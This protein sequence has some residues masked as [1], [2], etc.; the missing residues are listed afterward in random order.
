[1]ALEGRWLWDLKDWID[2]TW[3]AMYSHDLPLMGRVQEEPPAVAQAMGQDALSALSHTSMR[4]G[5]CGAKV[6]ATVLSR[7]MAKLRDGG[8]LDGEQ[9]GAPRPTVSFRPAA[10]SGPSPHFFVMAPRHAFPP[11]L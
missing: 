5:G 2:R 1:M 8:H 11:F 4:C 10:G 3:M 9:P 6:G 7:V